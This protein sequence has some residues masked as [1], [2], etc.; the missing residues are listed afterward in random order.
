MARTATLT[1]LVV[2]SEPSKPRRIEVTERIDEGARGR[3]IETRRGFR[4][5][6]SAGTTV[7]SRCGLCVVTLVVRIC[8]V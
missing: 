6:R 2:A 8:L 3:G 5:A 1:E 4:I 7:P